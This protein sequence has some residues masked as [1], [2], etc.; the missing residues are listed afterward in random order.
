[1]GRFLTA[2]AILLV[3]A[4]LFAGDAPAPY[5]ALAAQDP[6]FDPRALKVPMPVPVPVSEGKVIRHHLALNACWNRPAGKA[7]EET[8]LPP[9]ICVKKMT[10]EVPAE[11]QSVFDKRALVIVEARGGAK[12]LPITGYD[13]QTPGLT[14]II[15][16]LFSSGKT[17]AAAYMTVTPAGR[18]AAELPEIRGFFTAQSGTVQWL[19]YKPAQLGHTEGHL[20]NLG[21]TNGNLGNLGHTT[22]NLGNL[23]ATNGGLGNL[24]HTNGSLGNLGNLNGHLGHLDQLP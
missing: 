3:S 20:G 24:G 7:A 10:V 9:T 14:T 13:R 6:V 16:R 11:D 5:A 18:P 17:S 12:R 1:M 23:G 22:G 4:N 2:A 15:V 8:G 21:H 19:E